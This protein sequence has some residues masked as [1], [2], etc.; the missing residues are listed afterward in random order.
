MS[1]LVRKVVQSVRYDAYGHFGSDGMRC[2]SLVVDPVARVGVCDHGS[3]RNS[4]ELDVILH[5]CWYRWRPP[6]PIWS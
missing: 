5:V 1:S 2:R 3:P 4:T 6:C